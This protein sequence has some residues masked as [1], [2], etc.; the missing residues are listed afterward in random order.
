[1]KAETMRGITDP[2]TRLAAGIPAERG[3]PAGPA[4][5]SP[6]SPIRKCVAVVALALAVSILGWSQ[7]RAESVGRVGGERARWAEARR[8]LELARVAAP[9]PLP[10][11]VSPALVP[12]TGLRLAPARPRPLDPPEA[13][14]P[15]VRVALS[16]A[17]EPETFSV[18]IDDATPPR[19]VGYVRGANAVRVVIQESDSARAT[20]VG[21]GDQVGRWQLVHVGP[22]TATFS[23]EV[24]AASVQV[25][26]P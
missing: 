2:V 10:V 19:V 15:P 8:G 6:Q 14:P 25:E 18:P 17:D 22:R 26:L 7:W 23:I 11:A 5:L 1:M 24:P 12:E 21:E 3:F 16:T 20:W 9:V 4:L 13:G